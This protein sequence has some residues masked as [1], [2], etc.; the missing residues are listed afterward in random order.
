MAEMFH[1]EHFVKPHERLDDLHRNNFKIIQDPGKFCFGM[2]AVLLAAF[3]KVHRNQRHLDL[4]SGNGIIPIMLAARSKGACFYGIEIQEEMVDMATRSIALNKLQDRV[5]VVCGDIRGGSNLPSAHFDVVTANPPYMPV[6]AGQQSPSN[7]NAIARHEIMCTL[8]DVAAAAAR[9]LVSN[10]RFYMVH[11]PSRMSEIFAALDKHKLAPKTLCF[12]QP[13]F[14]QPPNMLL[15]SAVKGGG[16][17][18]KV[19]AP[20][21]IY[22]HKGEYT[23]EVYKIYYE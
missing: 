7:A 4:C 14:G 13:K 6:G 3:A 9:Y 17:H 16:A 21:I 10:G 22:D 15:I 12:V 19:Q 23:D 11:R 20:L 18:L 5:K 2:D 8:D 1:V